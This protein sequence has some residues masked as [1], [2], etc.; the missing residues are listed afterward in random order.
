MEEC[1]ALF[2]INS[3]SE[4]LINGSACDKRL[5]QNGSRFF[6]GKN[7]YPRA[8]VVVPEGMRRCSGPHDLSNHLFASFVCGF[9]TKTIR[10]REHGTASLQELHKDLPQRRITM[11]ALCTNIEREFVETW[12]RHVFV[13]GCRRHESAFV[14]VGLGREKERRTACKTKFI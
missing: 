9:R 14:R 6:A 8:T 7:S 10:Q 1:T 12:G 11:R 5:V 3:L 4:H 2:W 13:S